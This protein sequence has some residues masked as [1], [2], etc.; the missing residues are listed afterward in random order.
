MHA[1]LSAFLA[2]AWGCGFGP[3]LRSRQRHEEGQQ[4]ASASAVTQ[5]RCCRLGNQLHRGSTAP[6]SPRSPIVADHNPYIPSYK[7]QA[8]KQAK[9]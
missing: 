1:D 2:D 4:K 5:T 7:L 3:G 6:Y 8:D 9:R